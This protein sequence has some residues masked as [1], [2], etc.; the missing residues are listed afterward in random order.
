MRLKSLLI[1]SGAVLVLLI[2]FLYIIPIPVMSI[3]SNNVSPHEEI[4]IKIFNL[5]LRN[6]ELGNPYIIEKKEDGEWV[7]VET[8]EDCPPFTR[9]AYQLPPGTSYSQQLDWCSI[10]EEPG[11]YRVSKDV[12]YD[13][14]RSRPMRITVSA[15]FAVAGGD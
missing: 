14:E 3:S 15:V 11:S 1:I 10:S 8:V 6:L 2:V 9:E 4:S 13:R 12:T 7:K 5:G